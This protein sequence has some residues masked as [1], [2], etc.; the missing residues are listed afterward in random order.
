MLRKILFISL[1]IP[2]FLFWVFVTNFGCCFSKNVEYWKD[3]ATFFGGVYGPI[4]SGM[5]LYYLIKQ[6][7]I[8]NE[9]NVNAL[10]NLETAQESTYFNIMIIQLKTILA[11]IKYLKK[12]NVV[13]NKNWGITFKMILS[14]IYLFSY[15]D[16]LKT[17][18]SRNA[19]QTLHSNLFNYFLK[20]T[21]SI[22]LNNKQY[23]FTEQ[24]DAARESNYKE[25]NDQLVDLKAT[26]LYSVGDEEPSF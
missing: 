17:E 10:K 13:E 9:N 22:Y 5:A 24:R 12:L 4:F 16:T 2:I 8:A 23:L 6:V 21:E 25:I 1:I 3:F 18:Y 7:K 11:Q 19:I 20:D 26:I 15:K 14:D